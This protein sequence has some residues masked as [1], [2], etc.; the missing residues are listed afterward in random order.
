MVR[1]SC[2]GWVSFLA[3]LTSFATAGAAAQ[4]RETFNYSFDVDSGESRYFEIPTKEAGARLRV[5]FEVRS[6]QRFPGIRVAVEK[7]DQFERLRQH[8]PHQDL[9]FLSYRREGTLQVQLPES[10]RYAVVI[11]S[12]PETHRRCRVEMDVTLTTGPDPETLPVSYASPRTRLIVVT[13]S[14]GGFVL[15]LLLSGRALW[16]AARR[17]LR[18]F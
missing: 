3:W 17:S 15:I 2:A 11:N 14:L 6:P 9:A 18:L 1:R 4:H 8:Q 16:R 7:Q 5:E 10:G 12:P 13:A